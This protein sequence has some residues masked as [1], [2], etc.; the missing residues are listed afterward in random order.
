MKVRPG[1]EIASVTD[2]GCQRDNNEDSYAYWESGDDAVF[3]RSG[4]LAVVA[5]GMGG[6]EGGQFASQ[7]AV[8]TVLEL[9]GGANS[10]AD[11]QQRLITAF[12]EANNRVQQT[13]RQTPTL[14]GMGTTLT[15]FALIADHLYYAHVGDSR[16]YMLRARK[17]SLL[18]HDHSLVARLV[19]NGMVRPEDAENHPQK[20]VLTAAV[21]VSEAVQ[22]DTP[23]EPVP[24]NSGDVLLL[25][26]D[27]LWGQL[28]EGEI[29]SLLV[30]KAPAEACQALVDLAKKH[31]GPDNITLQVAKVA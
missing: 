31:G 25:C 27:G 20:H 29:T 21:G 8:E 23:V 4:R 24:V 19:Q 22:P 10:S 13:A 28:N 3:Q 1:L 9:Y 7:I 12:A 6:C 16:L 5:D 18:T 30:S 14:R 15:A 11:P 26:T 2:V 17:L